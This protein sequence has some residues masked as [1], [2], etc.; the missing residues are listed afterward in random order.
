MSTFPDIEHFKGHSSVRLGLDNGAFLGPSRGGDWLDGDQ[1]HASVWW[2]IEPVAYRSPMRGFRLRSGDRYIS[3]RKVQPRHRGTAQALTRDPAEAAV[4]VVGHTNNWTKQY[5]LLQLNT[6]DALSHDTRGYHGVIQR[7]QHENA[8]PVHHHFTWTNNIATVTQAQLDEFKKHHPN[9]ERIQKLTLGELHINTRGQVVD[10]DQLRPTEEELAAEADYVSPANLSECAKRVG[11][12]VFDVICLAL[13]AEGLR[14]SV[15]AST[16][17]AIAD[18][19]QPALNAIQK[20]IEQVSREG[21]TFKDKATGVFKILSAL[22]RA[23]CLG[24]VI[25]AFTKS[26]NW[27]T[28]I[29]YAV[30]SV[31]TIVAMVATDGVAFIAEVVLVLV[32]FAW[33]ITD[34]V[35]A[36]GACTDEACLEP[37]AVT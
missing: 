5:A 19:A 33:L 36:V 7:L 15:K 37:A 22:Y 30:T 9:D 21:A 29:L 13:G 3:T 31:A 4:F 16:V 34:F 17:D 1:S 8:L 14:S 25:S 12:V 35:R 32:A 2:E 11:W 10:W 27:W 18:A 6:Y 28:M 23:G 24:G 26:L 20:I